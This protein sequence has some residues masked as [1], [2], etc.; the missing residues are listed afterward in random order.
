[1]G[2]VFIHE[3]ASQVPDSNR[4]IFGATGQKIMSPVKTTNSSKMAIK[5][6]NLFS[7][8]HIDEADFPKRISNRKDVIVAKGNWTNFITKACF[9]NFYSLGSMM[10]PKVDGVLEC[11][12]DVVILRPIHKVQVKVILKIRGL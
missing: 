12:W 5:A 10:V 8:N 4:A 1:M 3:A 6:L 7:L 9:V 2:F 11:Y